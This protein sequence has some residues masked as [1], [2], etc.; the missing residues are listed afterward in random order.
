MPKMRRKKSLVIPRQVQI[1]G[2]RIPIR[3]ADCSDDE[4]AGLFHSKR[5]EI[6]LDPNQTQSQFESTFIHELIEAINHIYALEI[7]HPVIQTLGEALHQALTS[8]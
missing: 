2:H 1:A 8:T 3:S 4:A 6:L 7:P 5:M